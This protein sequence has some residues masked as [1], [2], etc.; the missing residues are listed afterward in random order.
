MEESFDHGN[1]HQKSPVEG[2]WCLEHAHG[3][4]WGRKFGMDETIW[5]LRI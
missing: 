5:G 1:E 4:I 2:L 3:L